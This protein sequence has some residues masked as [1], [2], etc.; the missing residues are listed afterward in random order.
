M[1]DSRLPP[2][3]YS[4]KETFSGTP[5]VSLPYILPALVGA[6]LGSGVTVQCE[7]VTRGAVA[8]TADELENAAENSGLLRSVS[9][10]SDSCDGVGNYYE[11]T[12]FQLTNDTIDWSL[13]AQLSS[14]EMDAV[15]ASSGGTLASGTYYYVVTAIDQT[16][17]NET[18]WVAGM[19]FSTGSLSEVG[20]LNISWENIPNATSYNVYRTSNLTSGG[21]L[22]FTGAGGLLA[23]VVG[24]TIYADDGS[25]SVAA[26]TDPPAVNT[27]QD[28]PAPGS[29]YYV[30]Y[31]YS[32]FEFNVPRRFTSLQDVI[33][34]YGWGSQLA[35]MAEFAMSTIPGYGNAAPAVWCVAAGNASDPTVAPQF[36]HYSTA[37]AALEQIEGEQLMVVVGINSANMRQAVKTHCEL[38]S[39]LEHKKERV[40]LCYAPNNT[41]I[42][43]SGDAS[44]II[45]MA[46][47]LSSKRAMLLAIDSGA[48]KGYVQDAG[49]TTRTETTL[50]PE[51]AAAAVAGKVCSLVDT[52]T[53][54]T[55]KQIVG[56]TEWIGSIGRVYNRTELIQLSEGGV[57]VCQYKSDSV[58]QIYKGIT[59]ETAVQDDAELSVVNATDTVA[60]AWREAIDPAGGSSQASLIGAKL[61]PG[62]LYATEMRTQ[63]V[64]GDL[65]AKRIIN[66]YDVNSITAS[67]NA[68]TLTQVDVSF[69]FEPIFPVNTVILTFSTSFSITGS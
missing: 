32:S 63:F 48:V 37:L 31:K 60:M 10:I 45:G 3:A 36:A 57:C 25:D 58:W 56:L 15:V 22:D 14:P 12:H 47:A 39:N 62:L 6:N 18:N 11:G 66:S 21:F 51:Y 64:L 54:L 44:S 53:P 17:V 65:V 43:S 34:T 33:T 9:R 8:N 7:E 13:G 67:Q 4:R 23:T 49:A 69:N 26:G 46:N 55:R 24:S 29:T 19:S 41:S 30:D 40:G 35:V 2:G 27:T 42:G 28:E 1:V 38:M 5:N 68:D 59:T 16:A 20:T 50:L 52:A 61:T